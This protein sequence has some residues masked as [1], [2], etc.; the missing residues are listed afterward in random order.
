MSFDP[1]TSDKYC[2]FRCGAF[3]FALPAHSVREVTVRPAVIVV[4]CCASVLAGL[5]HL[6]NEFLPVFSLSALSSDE[7]LSDEAPEGQMLVISGP[8]GAWGLLIDQVVALEPLEISI[9]AGASP[10]DEWSAVLVGSASYRDQVVRILEPN[11]LYRLGAR[12]LERYWAADEERRD[13]RQRPRQH[14]QGAEQ[15]LCESARA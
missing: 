1:Y 12:I 8:E 13:A 9:A 5:G 15:E 3:G 7:G 6:R 14:P 10:D 2:V 11:G 4:P